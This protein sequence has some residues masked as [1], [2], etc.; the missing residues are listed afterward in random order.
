MVYLSMQVRF[1][2]NVPKMLGMPHMPSARLKMGAFLQDM[3]CLMGFNG[4]SFL[5]EEMSLSVEL[6]SGKVCVLDMLPNFLTIWA[7]KEQLKALGGQGQ[8]CHV[9]GQCNH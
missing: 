3:Q 1:L 8:R 5:D 4:F 9:E 2:R 6:L 7:L